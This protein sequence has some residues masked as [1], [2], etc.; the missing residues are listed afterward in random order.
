MPVT[1]MSGNHLTSTR[2]TLE[3]P[4][5]LLY[6]NGNTC[7]GS[8][9]HLFDAQGLLSAMNNTFINGSLLIDNPTLR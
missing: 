5:S 2:S 4:A 3:L 9:V 6:F 1:N 8:D 7:L